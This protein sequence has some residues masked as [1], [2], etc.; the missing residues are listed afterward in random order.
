MLVQ[1]IEKQTALVGLE[2][3]WTR[4]SQELEEKI[5]FAEIEIK[6]MG[7]Q[8]AILFKEGE[9]L[10]VYITRYASVKHDHSQSSTISQSSRH[11]ATV[12]VPQT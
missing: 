1:S 10:K 7:D 6:K 8:K 4:K 12:Q 9:S 5:A 3:D 2:A 11:A